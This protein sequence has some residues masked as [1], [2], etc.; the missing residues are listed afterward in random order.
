MKWKLYQLCCLINTLC[1]IAIL[2]LV[3]YYEIRD[4]FSSDDIYIYACAVSMAIKNIWGFMLCLGYVSEKQYQAKVN[5]L[6]YILWALHL[7]LVAF[8]T[9]LLITYLYRFGFPRFQLQTAQIALLVFFALIP[10]S[11]YTVIFDLPL[12]RNIKRKLKQSLEF[13]IAEN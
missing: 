12:A 1:L 3:A 11:V 2:C 7:L 5:V 13:S 6:F 4:S 8:Q 9:Y 10:F